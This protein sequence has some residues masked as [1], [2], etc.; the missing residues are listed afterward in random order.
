MNKFVGGLTPKIFSQGVSI[1][2]GVAL[3]GGND[4]RCVHGRQRIAETQRRTT[5]LRDLQHGAGTSRPGVALHDPS[6]SRRD[7]EAAHRNT[8][9]PVRRRCAR[10]SAQLPIF[11][12]V[13]R[14]KNW[15]WPKWTTEVQWRKY[16]PRRPRN[17]WV[18]KGQ[19]PLPL[20][21]KDILALGRKT[22]PGRG[23][24]YGVFCRGG[25]NLKVRHC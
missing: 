14:I 16:R 13:A 4:W 9:R 8:H 19:G 5:H 18:P 12:H 7:D 10:R 1:M 22:S 3:S 21:K 11:S 2:R 17:A 20:G 25:E 6:P 15:G 23:R 24:R